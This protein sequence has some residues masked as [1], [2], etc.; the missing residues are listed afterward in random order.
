MGF[1]KKAIDPVVIF[2]INMDYVAGGLAIWKVLL[3]WMILFIFWMS[4]ESSI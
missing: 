1:W 2:W 4:P 3:A